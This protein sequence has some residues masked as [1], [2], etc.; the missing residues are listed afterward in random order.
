MECFRV[1]SFLAAN[2]NLLSC[3]LD[4]LTLKLLK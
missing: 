1:T 3:E 2:L 4:N